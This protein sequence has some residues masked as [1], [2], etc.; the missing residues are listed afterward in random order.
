MAFTVATPQAEVQAVRDTLIGALKAI[1][2]YL[3]VNNPSLLTPTDA[4][5]TA[6]RDALL[7]LQDRTLAP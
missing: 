6:A 4:A 7:A 1:E 2:G 5:C 3:Q